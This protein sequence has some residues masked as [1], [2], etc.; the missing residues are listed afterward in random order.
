MA[1]IIAK[2]TARPGKSAALE[3]VLR[4]LVAATAKEPGAVVYDLLRPEGQENVFVVTERYASAAARESHLASE[5]LKTA[6]AKISDCLAGAPDIQLLEP[7]TGI[8]HESRTENGK[9]VH[10]AVLPIGPVNLVYAQTPN[11]I[12]ACGALD[13][14]ALERF[15]IAAARVK[16]A[17]ASV[18]NY[19]DLLAGSVREANAPAQARGIRIGMTGEEAL[20]RL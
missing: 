6:L 8:R 12:L 13:P 2:L 14:A 15:G 9:P 1:S 7:L 4:E 17:G 19:Q 16:P 3:A 20:K 11:G 18:A 5:H 10:V